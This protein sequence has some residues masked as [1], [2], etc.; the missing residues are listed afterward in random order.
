MKRFLPALLSALAV[1]AAPILWQAAAQQ[2]PE[3]LAADVE[4]PVNRPVGE[5]R[6]ATI[7][8]IEMALEEVR[9]AS[10]R[11]GQINPDFSYIEGDFALQRPGRVRFDYDDPSPILIVSDGTTVAMEDTDL[12]TFD[13]VPIGRHPLKLMFDRNVDFAGNA[14]IVDLLVLPNEVNLTIRDLKGEVEGELT[15]IL[16]SESYQLEGWRILDAAGSSTSVQLMD[17]E[18]NKRL[19]QRLFRIE[20]PEDAEDE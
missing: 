19:S 10:G 9:T 12:E 11:F 4:S 17:V 2:T 14:E 13:R 7:D 6:Q 16:D 15:M 8:R 20:D 3:Q 1:S 18:T 5:E